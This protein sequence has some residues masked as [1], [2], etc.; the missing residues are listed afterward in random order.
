MVE[1]CPQVSLAALSDNPD[2]G[3]EDAVSKTALAPLCAS[4]IGVPVFVPLAVEPQSAERRDRFGA[5]MTPVHSLPFLL[6]LRNHA[7]AGLP[8]DEQR[9]VHL[10]SGV[11]TSLYRPGR[12]T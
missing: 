5:M 7:V 9:G 8:R 11:L 2:Y 3:I 1:G 6:T 4:L 10:E 12:R